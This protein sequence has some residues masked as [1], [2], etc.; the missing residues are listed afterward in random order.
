MDNK[1]QL[2]IKRF[3]EILELPLLNEGIPG[4][5]GNFFNKFFPTTTDAVRQLNRIARET[6]I[7]S[8][9]V[10]DFI[11][12]LDDPDLYDQLT[13]IDKR[14]IIRLLSNV[15]ELSDELFQNVLNTFDTSIDELN[16]AVYNYMNRSEN[17]LSYR[18]AINELFSEAP[19]LAPLIRNK[20]GKQFADFKPSSSTPTPST[21]VTKKLKLTPGEIDQFNKV[22]ESKTVKTF[23]GDIRKYWKADVDVIKNDIIAY[24][25]GFLEEIKDLKKKKQIEPLVNAYSVQIS[26]L[27]DRAEI[28]MNGA[29]AKILEEAGVDQNLVE[30]IKFGNEPFFVTYKKLRGKDN[31]KLYEIML[32]T[33]KEFLSEIIDL[34]KGIFRKEGNTIIRMFN[35]KT[36]VGQWFYTNQWASLNKLYR[37]AIKMSPG[38]SKTKLLKYISATM[39][40]SSI[41]FVFG[42]L[43]KSGI[44]GFMQLLVGPYFNS[45][46]DIFGGDDGVIFGID[47]DKWKIEIPPAGVATEFLGLFG[48]I[49]DAIGQEIYDDVIEGFKEHGMKDTFLRLVPGGLLTYPESMATNLIEFVFQTEDEVP[50]L[51]NAILSMVG[52]DPEEVDSALKELENSDVGETTP[53]ETL[54]QDLINIMPDNKVNELVIQDGN[55]YWGKP[56]Y[57]VEK[58]PE[59]NKWLVFVPGSGWYEITKDM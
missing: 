11:R 35:P 46:L 56:E 12:V 23:A 9:V 45:L 5:V 43:L 36:S 31:Q 13:L 18:Q 24:S 28:K 40:A 55:I 51:R 42:S 32:E 19:E 48:R 33:S 15:P 44:S 50:N 4:A 57:K 54:P 6:E 3:K 58:R 16:L 30:K 29:A 49:L 1:L 39:F 52:M 47:V 22:V 8:K 21:G 20:H 10:D 27:L 37:L 2:E 38:E 25:E 41:G 59:I 26:R 17:P 7:D 53:T 14:N 34:I